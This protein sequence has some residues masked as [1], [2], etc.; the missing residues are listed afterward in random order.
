MLPPWRRPRLQAGPAAEGRRQRG[1]GLERSAARSCS[2]SKRS[3]APLIPTMRPPTPRSGARLRSTTSSP[4]RTRTTTSARSPGDSGTCVSAPGPAAGPPSV[5]DELHLAPVGQDEVVDAGGGGVEQPQPDRLGDDVEVGPDRAV[6]QHLVAERADRHGHQPARAQRRRPGRAGVLDH[7]RDVV[8]AVRTGRPDRC[9]GRV[10]DEEHPVDAA[11]H[12]LGRRAV[13]VRVV[14]G[15][16]RGLVDGPAGRPP[17]ARARP[18]WCG[19][20]SASAGR[21]T[22]CQCRVLAS[23]RSL[24]TSIRTRSPRVR[25]SV[26]PRC[27]PP[28]PHVSVR[29][30]PVRSLRPVCSRRSKTRVPSASTVDAASGGT[31]SGRSKATAPTVSTRP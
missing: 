11:A 10:V 14:P 6:D 1:R 24:V 2:T 21:C 22:P 20:P 30:R 19:P 8:H 4:G 16:R 26:G 25:R 28:M 27:A 3:S 9:R 18:S 13:A 12:V 5:A 15:R 17:S 29:P 31:R 7:N 23:G